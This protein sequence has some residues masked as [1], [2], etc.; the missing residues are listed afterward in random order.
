MND[1]IG[2][3]QILVPCLKINEPSLED[4][5]QN[6]V[7]W[8]MWPVSYLE[9]FDILEIYPDSISIMPKETAN[10]VVDKYKDFLFTIHGIPNIDM[11]D[12]LK[13]YKLVILNIACRFF[14]EKYDKEKINGDHW[15][16]NKVTQ[17]E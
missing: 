13:S 12:N 6:K 7:K 8:F 4:F 17:S 16:Y 3:S 1:L 10:K 9:K 5:Q 15:T 2:K 14:D 11:P